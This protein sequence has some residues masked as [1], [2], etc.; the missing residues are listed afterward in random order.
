MF[1]CKICR[2]SIIGASLSEPHTSGTDPLVCVYIYIYVYYVRLRTSPPGPAL[3]AN[4]TGSMTS[5]NNSPYEA[6]QGGWC[7]LLLLKH[8]KA[9]GSVCW[10]LLLFLYT[11]DAAKKRKNLTVR[12]A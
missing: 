5:F 8:G 7:L 2:F 12:P 1:S 6:W 10:F 3:Q 11:F 9:D 4:V